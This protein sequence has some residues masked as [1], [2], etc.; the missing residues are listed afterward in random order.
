[1]TGRDNQAAIALSLARWA[2]THVDVKSHAAGP[3][4][5]QSQKALALLCQKEP[6]PPPAFG[7]RDRFVRG[8]ILSGRASI[9]NPFPARLHRFR[10]R[11][12]MLPSPVPA[13]PR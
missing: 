11:P 9:D 8:V 2:E 5:G 10:R 6:K 3:C 7:Q 12:S 1:M 13:S 4:A